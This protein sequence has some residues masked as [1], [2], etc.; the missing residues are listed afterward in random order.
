M[1]Q[2]TRFTGGIG[3]HGGWTVGSSGRDQRRGPSVP[4][5]GREWRH[6]TAP[7]VTFVGTATGFGSAVADAGNLDGDGLDDIAITSTNDG[8]GKVFIFSRKS[9]P[10]SWGSTT[11]WPATLMDTQ[12]NY[13]IS[14]DPGLTGISFRNL[15]RLGNFDGVGADD[16]THCVPTTYGTNGNGS[17]SS[18]RAARRSPR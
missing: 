2:V 9:P 4:V 11:S 5:H 18:S 7:T 3:V 14:T 6:A 10:A 15:A 16:S 17:R 13:V 8:N 12:A 1:A